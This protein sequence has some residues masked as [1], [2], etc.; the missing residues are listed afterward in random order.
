MAPLVVLTVMLVAYL[1]FG[2]VMDS[3][4]MIL[5]TIPIF[6]PIVETLDFRPD[7]GRGGHLV[8]HPRPDRGRSRI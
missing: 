4:S 8:R 3:L 1:I 5:L 2:C 7:P 6:Y